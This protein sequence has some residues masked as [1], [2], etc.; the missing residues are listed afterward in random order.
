MILII[1]LILFTTPVHAEP[2]DYNIRVIGTTPSELRIATLECIIK[3]LSE[4]R[5]Y[6]DYRVIESL[7]YYDSIADI[8]K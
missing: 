2:P 1:L 5:V 8:K 3:R 4:S 6:Y 7:C